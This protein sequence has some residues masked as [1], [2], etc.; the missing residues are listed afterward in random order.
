M[1]RRGGRLIVVDFAPHAL[2][3]LR[4]EHAHRR[5]GFDHDTVGRWLAAA[6]LRVDA[7]TDLAADAP[8]DKLTV[9]LW[10][11]RDPHVEVAAL[12]SGAVSR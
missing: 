11:A 7:V 2:E 9:T 1:V 6:G 12:A 10:L 5:L 8:G 3:F 4:E